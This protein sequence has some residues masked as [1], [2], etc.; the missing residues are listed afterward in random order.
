MKTRTLS[1]LF[2]LAALLLSSVAFARGS[3]RVKNH[4]P[5]ELSGGVWKLKFEIDYGSTPHLA[6][7]P[8][9]L[10]FK[11]TTLYERSLTDAYPKNPVSSRKPLRNQTPINIPT[12]VG[13]ADMS[14]TIHRKT[15]F[16]IKLRRDRDFEA[17]EYEL[18]IRLVSGGTLG[19]SMKIILQGE[20]KPVD[21][22]S[23]SFVA[24]PIKKK[25]KKKP[26]AEDKSGNEDQDL[27]LSDI[28]DEDADTGD[29]DTDEAPAPPAV[30]PKQ[31]GCGCQLPGGV[32]AA[33]SGGVFALM[34]FGLVG[35]L[36]PRRRSRRRQRS[37]AGVVA[38]AMLVVSSISCGGGVA[39]A[40]PPCAN[41]GDIRHPSSAQLDA[42]VTGSKGPPTVEDAESFMDTTEAELKALAIKQERA[43]W[44]QYTYITKD[45]QEITA[46]ADQAIMEFSAKAIKAARRFDDI[47][48]PAALARKFLLLRTSGT[49]PAPDES[50]LTKELTTIQGEIRGRYG[51]GSYCPKAGGALRKELAKDPKNAA[52][53]G[54]KTPGLP[55]S[56][57]ALGK[58]TKIMANSRN[59]AALLEAWV[60][61]R[62]ISPPMRKSYQRFVE[63][64]NMGARA[65][66]FK[67]VGDL[68]R[69][70]YDMSASAFRA[71]VERMY[72]QVEPFYKELHCYVR[73]KL[74]KHYGKDVVADG[75]PI[76]AH[77]LGNMWSQSWGNIYP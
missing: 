69:S 55:G 50:A 18:Q 13:F 64:G 51:K 58:L 32:M 48:L 62:M 21:R 59:Q 49:L 70:G 57:V 1:V 12:D 54:C 28:E 68:W 44:I 2:V 67:D 24:R 65:I 74:Q 26:V 33:P 43:H 20:N 15:R 19:R 73:D 35:L 36:R 38:G 45:T 3:A 41:C 56:G 30:A 27:D 7:V 4:R 40:P 23:I 76:P 17:G 63:L 9:V 53:L 16:S 47:E 5:K 22:R 6:H 8:V 77:L 72:K 52:A 37:V 14:G 11:M 34:L 61:W 25:A 71:D 29:S 42:S 10:R 39:Y 31:G 60:G 66:G 46:E 75:A